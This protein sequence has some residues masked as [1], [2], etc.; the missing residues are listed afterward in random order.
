MVADVKQL[1]AGLGAGAVQP[2]LIANPQQAASLIAYYGEG[3][4]VI[5]SPNVTAGMVIALDASAFVVASGTP[6]FKIG[7]DAVV[8]M[9]DTNPLQL[10]TGVQGSGVI[11]TPSK[12]A[13]QTDTIILRMVWELNWFL[14]RTGA[15]SWTS[16][17]TW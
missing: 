12:S 7:R 8:H 1:T 17:V 13:F 6:M 4:T 14:R 11:A 16:A 10:S 9:E 3:V 5:V 2:V 15:V